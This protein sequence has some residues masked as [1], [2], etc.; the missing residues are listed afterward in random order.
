MSSGQVGVLTVFELINAKSNCDGA[1]AIEVD[2]YVPTN[3]TVDKL[4]VDAYDLSDLLQVS[5]LLGHLQQ[6]K[7]GSDPSTQQ[8][9]NPAVGS[10]RVTLSYACNGKHWLVAVWL[11]ELQGM[12]PP[13]YHLDTT[14]IIHV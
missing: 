9:L 8:S 1:G 3:M 5:R 10:N 7:S 4:F 11:K 13:K 14:I 2:A 6:V 12:Q